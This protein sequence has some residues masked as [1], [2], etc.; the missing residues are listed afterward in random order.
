[1]RLFVVEP[2]AT[3]GMIHYAYQLCTAMAEAGA[4]VTLVTA[5]SYELADWPHNFAVENRI[6]WWDA[7]DASSSQPPTTRLGKW[8]RKIRWSVRRAKRGLRLVQEWG[9]LTRYLLKERPDI[10]QFGK[11]NFPFEAFFLAWLRF[12]GLYLTQI[13]HEFEL[14]EQ[15]GPV[16]YLINRLYTAVYSQFSIIF[17]HGESNRTPFLQLFPQAEG[18]TAVIPFGNERIFEEKHGGEIAKQNLQQR[19]HLQG[20]KPIVLFFGNL[21]PSKGVDDLLH[22]FA[23]LHKRVDAQLI[24]AGYPTKFIDLPAL[25]QT[26]VNLHIADSVIFDSRYIPI[27]DV[28]PLMELATV[29]AY[30]YHSSTQSASLQVAYCFGRPVVATNVGG[31]PDAVDDGKSGFLVPPL[32]PE[33][34]GQALLNIIDDPALAKEMGAYAYHLSQTR[35]AW[36]PIG[37]R[38]VN[39]YQDAEN[40]VLVDRVMSI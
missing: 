13:C 24:V 16:A 20:D 40:S 36:E 14:R 27:T 9:R 18:K 37:K 23:W 21:T 32:N 17:L 31:L 3:G 35:F 5:V 10:V 2:L 22:A 33:A 4:D 12:R 19:Y 7:Y 11:I 26:A 38:I 8:Q 39:I 29:V 28:G 1:M 6:H 34:L 25:Q 30:P 15:S